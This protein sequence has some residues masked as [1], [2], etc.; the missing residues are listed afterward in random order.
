MGNNIAKGSCVSLENMTEL[1]NDTYTVRR[2]SGQMENGWIISPP[3]MGNMPEWVVYYA[4]KD[5]GSWRI[6]M[7]NNERNPNLHVSGWRHLDS[8]Y[9][10][11]F[12]D[13]QEIIDA[14]RSNTELILNDLEHKRLIK[15]SEKIE[16]V[17]KI[18]IVQ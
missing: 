7:H 9:P 2:T 15:E 5:N 14:W 6:F 10:T 1:I 3:I 17:P 8:I 11:H 16:G 4:L 18:T 13:D 12:A